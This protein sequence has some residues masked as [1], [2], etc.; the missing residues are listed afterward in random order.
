MTDE[1]LAI[2]F[3]GRHDNI[4]ARMR[5]HATR[6]LT[7]MPRFND[8]VSRIEVVA[9]HVHEYPEV[10][11]IVHMRSG[12]PLVAK[13]RSQTFSSAIDE[14]VEKMER[15]LKRLKEKRTDH[16]GLGAGKAD[17]GSVE[18]ES[19]EETYEEVVRRS[20]RG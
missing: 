5:D 2:E 8:Q 11:L 14:L 19:T 1:T 16:K 6:K 12:A 13:R 4:S 9:D 20:L 17:G 18:D 10:E 15:Q 3:K 7:R